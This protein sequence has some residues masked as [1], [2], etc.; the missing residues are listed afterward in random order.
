MSFIKSI[1]TEDEAESL[2]VTIMINETPNGKFEE[3]EDLSS[4]F[5]NDMCDMLSESIDVLHKYL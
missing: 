2:M 4:S 1:L 5:G 3:F